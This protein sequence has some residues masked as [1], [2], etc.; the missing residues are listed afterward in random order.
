MT[1][2]LD[3]CALL[4]MLEDRTLLSP[5]ASDVAAREETVLLFSQV[6]LIEIAIKTAAGKLKIDSDMQMLPRLAD[7]S[8]IFM[9][10]LRN[11]AVFRLSSLPPIHRDPFDRLLICEAMESEATICTPDELIRS[12]PIPTLW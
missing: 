11:E 12:Y 2:L 7:A 10:P 3:T 5:A 8:G 6:S 1:I 9:L 4:W